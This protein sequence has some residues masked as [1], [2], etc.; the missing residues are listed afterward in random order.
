M[1]E[2]PKFIIYEGCRYSLR[3]GYYIYT[4]RLHRRIWKD[5][6]GEIPPNHHIHHKNGDST[7]NRIENLECISKKDHHKLHFDREKQ[8]RILHKARDAASA[9]HR[10]EYGRKV[11]SK[12]GKESWNKREPIK[13]VCV[14]CCKSFLTKNLNGT[15]YCSQK[16]RSKSQYIRDQI[17]LKCLMC[18]CTYRTFKKKSPAKTCSPKCSSTYS[19][20]KRRGLLHDFIP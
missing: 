4:E 6:Y 1:E 3:Q 9:W 19:G 12:M 2:K 18:Q 20:L 8:T 16:C 11:H 7:D 17:E 14:I 13:R 5:H 10:S 15:K